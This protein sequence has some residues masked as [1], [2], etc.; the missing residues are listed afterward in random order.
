MDVDHLVMMANQI[1]RNLAARGDEA[2]VALMVE[3]IQDFWDPRMKA[4]ILTAD[5]NK[6]EPIA[7]SAVA[8][9]GAHH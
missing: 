4:G 9:F 6:F 5:P 3:H 8:Q 2:A 1:A 7:A